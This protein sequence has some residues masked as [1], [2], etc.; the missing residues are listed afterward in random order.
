MNHQRLR[1]IYALLFLLLVAAALPGA[2]VPE[3][4]RASSTPAL[5]GRTLDN[6]GQPVRG[7]RVA[8]F[9]DGV[10]LP[11][12]EAETQRDGAFILDL[13]NDPVDQVRLEV[14]HPHFQPGTWDASADDLQRLRDGSAIRVPD[15]VLTRRLTAAFW[16]ATLTF[17]GMLALIATE[18]LHGTMAGLLGVAVVLGV[19]LVGRR[20]NQGL[21]IFDFE[22]AIEY[23]DFSVVFLVLGMMIV[24]SIIEETGVFQWTAYQAYRLSRGR[25][26]LLVVILMVFTWIA[27]A[28]LDNVTTMLLVAPIT[29]QIAL[30][31]GVDPLSLLIPEMLA[32]NVGGISTLIGTPNNILIG[33]YAGVTFNDFLSNVTPAV[34]LSMLVLALYVILIYRK[35][36]QKAAG[37][38]SPALLARLREN[39]RITQPEKLRKAGA[40]FVGILVLFVLGERIHLVP[41]VTAILGAVTMLL[42]VR[43]NIEQMLRVVDWTTLMF[44]IALFIVVG[45]IQEVGLISYIAAAIHSLVGESVVAAT[46]VTIWLTGFLCIFIPTIPLTA[47]LLPVVGFLTRTLPVSGSKVLFYSLSVGSGLGA[48]TSVIGAANNLVTAGIAERAGYPITFRRFLTRGFPAA[49]LTL[50]IGTLWVLIRF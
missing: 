31:L 3:G 8:L 2:I 20:F 27:S 39:A 26:W 48:N 34:A 16:I 19:S 24:V 40:V 29:L 5:S 15:F 44:F 21:F 7:A 43:A 18:R 41:A 13:Q 30:T 36:Y 25:L 23:V 32:S 37:T 9:L 50:I 38:A 22:Q 45:A 42:V 11:A 28:L 35:Q 14:T 17:V 6:Q 1:P 49:V 12:A 46:L 33:S 4:A 47:A 10:E